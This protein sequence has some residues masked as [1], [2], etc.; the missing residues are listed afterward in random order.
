M[1]SRRP[2][3]G[4]RQPICFFSES[5]TDGFSC[6]I[7]YMAFCLTC[8]VFL[9]NNHCCHTRYM[10]IVSLIMK[11]EKVEKKVHMRTAIKMF[12]NNRILFFRNTPETKFLLN[13]SSLNCL[14]IAFVCKVHRWLYI[15]LYQG[16]S[17]H[18]RNAGT[19]F[20]SYM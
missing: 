13:C 17:K 19:L 3:N 5:T 14:T 10:R 8:M 11:K 7:C 4:Y 20:L 16:N 9:I 12:E 15:R 1:C 18:L 6:N 2:Q